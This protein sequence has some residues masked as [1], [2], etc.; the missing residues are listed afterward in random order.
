MFFSLYL[1]AKPALCDEGLQ[2]RFAFTLTPPPTLTHLVFISLNM[3][4]AVNREV[5]SSVFCRE[6]VNR[7]LMVVSNCTY[8]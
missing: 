4:K 3:W 5:K 8:M 2:S 7:E 6:T 1:S